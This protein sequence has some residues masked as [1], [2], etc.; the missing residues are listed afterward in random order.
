[1][2]GLGLSGGSM[3]F[4]TENSALAIS[5]ASNESLIVSSSPIATALILALFYKDERMSHSQVLA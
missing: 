2:L 4:L 3:Y 5:N 1:M